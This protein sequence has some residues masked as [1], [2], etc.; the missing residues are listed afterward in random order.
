MDP[1]LEIKAFIATLNVPTQILKKDYKI[2]EFRK[3]NKKL[4]KID[5]LES[6]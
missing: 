1:I 6:V 2:K 3:Y 4:Y 5:K